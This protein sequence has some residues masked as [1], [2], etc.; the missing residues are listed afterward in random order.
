MTA[1]IGVSEAWWEHEDTEDPAELCR[2]AVID[3]HAVV[4]SDVFVLL[5]TELSEGKAVESG[6]MLWLYERYGDKRMFL[7][8]PKSNI[9]HY[10]PC[11]EQV[12][13]VE[14]VVERL[15]KV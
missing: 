10:L 2:Q 12:E 3:F 9:F 14:E 8:G 6:I 1:G 7:V 11:W 15:R 13:S 4:E 5:N